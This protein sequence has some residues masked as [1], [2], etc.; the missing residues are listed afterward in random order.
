M[1]LK[2]EIFNSGMLL[3]QMPM[4]QVQQIYGQG[5]VPT[6]IAT[7]QMFVQPQLSVVSQ[8]LL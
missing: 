5:V 4:P 2:Q 7:P 8:S 1:L 6:Q 3:L